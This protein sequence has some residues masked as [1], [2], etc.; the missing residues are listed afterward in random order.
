MPGG[1]YQGPGPGDTQWGPSPEEQQKNSERQLKDMKMGFKQLARSI[2]DFENMIKRTEKNG[3]VV[4]DGIKQKVLTIKDL[5]T[6]AN[7]ATT[8]EEFQELNAQEAHDLFRELDEFR[9]EVVEKAERLAG[10][11]RGMK[12]MEQGLKMF[13]KQV[14]RL[15]K[16]K[17]AVPSDVTDNIAKLKAL[18]QQIKNAKTAEEMDAIDFDSMQDLMQS[19]EESRQKLEHLARWPMALKD[20]NRQLTQ[21]QREVK[22]AKTIADRLGKKGMD[23]QDLYSAFA[24]AVGKLKSVRDSAVEKMASGDAEGAFDLLENEFFG[25]MEDVWQHF[26]VLSM[27]SNMGQFTSE[28]KREMTKASADIKRLKKK[29]LNTSELEDLYARAKEKGQEIQDMIKSKDFDED[30]IKEAFDEMENV[31]QEFD[32]KIAELTG[33]REDMPWETGPQQ[34][35]RIEMNK[36]VQKFMPQRRE[37]GPQNSGEAPMSQESFGPTSPVPGI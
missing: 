4:P 19:M 25:Q 1:Q 7:S 36:D 26:K 9:Q 29:G 27:M 16:Q 33:A 20:I 31:G 28:F 21:L 34:F 24:D 30:T 23:V 11:K 6:K 10:M 3:T 18:I 15:A 12:G 32:E 8:M 14:A 17:V 37:E 2:K 22:R 13:E 5:I 35:K